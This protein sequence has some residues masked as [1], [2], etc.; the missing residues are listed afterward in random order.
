MMTSLVGVLV[1]VALLW[2]R[3]NNLGLKFDLLSAG[4]DTNVFLEAE[5]VPAFSR[6]LREWGLE[7][8][9]D[10]K[11]EA[12][13]KELEHMD[14][15]QTRPVFDG[16]YWRMV[17]C[18]NTGRSKDVV[19]VKPLSN[20]AAWMTHAR[21]IAR[22]GRALTSGIPVQYAF[23]QALDSEG[24]IDRDTTPSGMRYMADR[25]EDNG[26]AVAD[27]A[28]VSYYKAF[29]ITP[30]QQRSIENAYADVRLSYAER[31][32]PHEVPPEHFITQQQ[33]W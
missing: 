26:P 1:M 24:R 7:R 3:C 17:R 28:R 22:C 5:D 33:F 19:T 10:F 8:G 30:I 4:D 29:G 21:S 14:F 2:T 18:H 32:T 13:A 20:E 16:S 12:V 25:L 11:V 27:A 31:H 6:G 15:C 9:F 23:Y